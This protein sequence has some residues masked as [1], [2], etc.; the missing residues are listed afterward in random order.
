[1]FFLFTLV[2]IE[3]DITNAEAVVQDSGEIVTAVRAS[4]AIPGVF[5]TVEYKGLRLVD[6]GVIRNFPV[7]DAIAMGAN[8]TIGSNVTQG[9]LKKEKLSNP[10]QILLQIA[11]LKEDQDNRKQIEMTDLY[12]Q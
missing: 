11:F 2:C 3:T 9:L 12:R 7:S 1:M 5:T 10:I 4:M 8:Y 6:G